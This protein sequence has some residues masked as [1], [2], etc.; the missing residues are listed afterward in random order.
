MFLA[1]L[2]AYG[3]MDHKFDTVSSALLYGYLICAWRY[4]FNFKQYGLRLLMLKWDIPY[5]W[6]I[7]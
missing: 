2:K 4:C 6:L 5:L 7:A 1:A 3:F